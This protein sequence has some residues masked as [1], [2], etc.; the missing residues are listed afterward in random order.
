MTRTTAPK[1]LKIRIMNLKKPDYFDIM[2]D[3]L[4]NIVNEYD[5]DLYR[6]IEKQNKEVKHIEDTRF[7]KVGQLIFDY[8][9]FRYCYKII[10]VNKKSI[11]ILRIKGKIVKRECVKNKDYNKYNNSFIM[12]GYHKYNT[13]DVYDKADVENHKIINILTNFRVIVEP[14]N[15]DIFYKVGRVYNSLNY[16]DQLRNNKRDQIEE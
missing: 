4:K 2:P 13:T 10:K 6:K 3:V 7:L 15:E 11:N 5:N 12:N 14:E 8:G 16:E 1:M 9:V